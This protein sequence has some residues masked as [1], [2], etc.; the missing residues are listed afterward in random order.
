MRIYEF[1]QAISTDP[2]DASEVIKE[3]DRRANLAIWRDASDS[4]DARVDVLRELPSCAS[5]TIP[6]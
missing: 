3:E 1:V 6:V 2:L 5:F 4:S